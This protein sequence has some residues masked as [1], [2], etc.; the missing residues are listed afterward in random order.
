VEDKVVVHDV[1][2]EPGTPRPDGGQVSPFK[3]RLVVFRSGVEL[4]LYDDQTMTL[5]GDGDLAPYLDRRE[6]RYMLNA[7]KEYWNQ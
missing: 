7:M 3:K 6:M 4:H 5:V 1:V 2:L